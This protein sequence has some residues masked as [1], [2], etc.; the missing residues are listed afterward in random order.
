MQKQTILYEQY[1]TG[2]IPINKYKK[3]R[4]ALLMTQRRKKERRHVKR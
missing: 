2:Y 4:N 3:L 1:I